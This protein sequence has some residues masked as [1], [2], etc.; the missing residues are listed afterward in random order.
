MP[1]ILYMHNKVIN[2]MINKGNGVIVV[3]VTVLDKMDGMG[4]CLLV[5]FIAQISIDG[6]IM[7]R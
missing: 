1:S 6:M 4:T 2:L 7:K 3:H 5:L